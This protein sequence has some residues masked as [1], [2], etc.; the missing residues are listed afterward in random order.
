MTIE[1]ADMTE[2]EAY[3]GPQAS[4][5]AEHDVDATIKERIKKIKE[6]AQEEDTRPTSQLSLRTILGGD[7]L[8]TEFIRGQIWLFV[9]VVAFSV[10]YV[11]YRYQCQ[12]DMQT[13]NKLEQDLRGARNKALAASSTLT[14]LCRESRMLDMLKHNNDSLL[15][16]ADQ[17]PYIIQLDE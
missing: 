2:V 9:L 10:V 12:Q 17:P 16:M 11:A 15:H 13:I 7:M 6:S 3:D 8:T 1:G 4:E 14:G 5:E